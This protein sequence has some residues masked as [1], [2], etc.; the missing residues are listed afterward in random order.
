MSSVSNLYKKASLSSSIK[1]SSTAPRLGSSSVGLNYDDLDWSKHQNSFS[2]LFQFNIVSFN[3][4]APVY[5]RLQSVDITTGFRKR[6]SQ[7][8]ELWGARALRTADFFRREVLGSTDI[9]GLQEF[10]LDSAY[11][12]IFEDEFAQA[13]YD[14]HVLKRPGKKLD[15]VALVIKSQDFEV[16]GSEHVF[17]STL[18]DR[19]ALLLWLK[20]RE[21][22]K[23]LLVANTHLSFPHSTADRLDQMTQ[24]QNLT[25]VI[26]TFAHR[27]HIDYATR[28]IMGDFNV[29]SKSPVCNHLRSVG[30]ASC[31]EVYVFKISLIANAYLSL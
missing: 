17:L 14:V 23:D 10:W 29:E 26:D 11:R 7:K 15:G 1:Q 28:V 13:G 3:L 18:G 30:Y 6:E 4:L 5:K 2:P 31:F 16:L 19:V 12:H 20:H 8:E 27:Y 24:M 22:G 9:I 25:G 21:S